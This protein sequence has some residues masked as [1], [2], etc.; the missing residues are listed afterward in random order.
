MLERLILEN[1]VPLLSSNITKVDLDLKHLITL[2]MARNG[3]GKSAI[4]RELNPLPPENGNY[5]AGGRKYVEWRVG[6]RLYKMDSNTG[7]GN[8]HSFRIDDGPELNTG[9]TF[10]AQKE[11]VYNHFNKMDG[12]LVKVL[13]GIKILDRL[14]AMSPGR[15]KDIILQVYPNDTEYALG[16]YFKL[17]QERNDLKAAIKNQVARYTEENNKLARINQLGIAEL[18]NR[19]KQIDTDLKNSLLLRGQLE[20]A[21]LDPDLQA[22]F[23]L[24]NKLVDKLLTNKLSGVMHSYEELQHAHEFAELLVNKYQ[25]QISVLKGVI[26]ES[27]S[28]LDGMEDLLKDPQ[29]FH[30]QAQHLAEDFKRTDES[31]KKFDTLLNSYPVFEEGGSVFGGIEYVAESFKSYLNRVAVAST[32]ELT[33]GTYKQWLLEQEQLA[34]KQRG[35]ASQLEQLRHKLKHYENADTINCP[36]CSHEFKVGIT[37]QD[38][39]AVRDQISAFERQTDEIKHRVTTLDNLIE[40]DAEWY[41]TMNQLFVFVRENSNVKVLP[42][43]IKHFDIGKV[44][45]SRL[46]NALDLFMERSKLLAY[47]QTLEDEK[48]V[49]DGRLELYARE[50][51]LDMATHVQQ[52][53]ADLSKATNKAKFYQ[54]RAMVLKEQLDAIQSYGNDMQ[55][56]RQ[57]QYELY[58]GMSNRADVQLRSYVDQNISTL[59][60]SKDEHLASIIQNK[61]LN[62]VVESISTDIENLKRR[63]NSVSVLMDS[64]CP[65]KGLIGKLMSDFINSLCGNINAVIKK[66]WN[67]PLYIKPCAKENGDLTY[68]FPVVTGDKAPTP[69]LSDCSGGETDV[70]DWAFRFVLLDYVGFPFPLIMDEIGVSFDEIKRGRFFNFIQEYT[71]GKNARQ[72]FMVSHYFSQYGI[73]K[74]P[75]VIGL[76]YEGLTMPGEPNKHSLIV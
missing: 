23:A 10:S 28:N 30:S 7:V 20:S 9:G 70:L 69:D 51:L 37:K 19:I 16:V 62:A 68:K 17:K 34:N 42:E 57:L 67:T 76:H 64:L 56:L 53:E 35:I 14:S 26:G 31:I 2:I 63:L 55:K 66:I 49:V 4:M 6:K 48:K 41:L 13:H 29:A 25:E 43:L 21:K 1:Y 65:N 71:Q 22:K 75:N 58:S 54:R 27:A 40:N 12:G 44:P 60:K 36:D 46:C 45:S 32:P 33:S 38:V 61:S 8:G 74:D 39:Q 5:T 24:F 59:T 73:F 47:R 50:N 72:L 18:E 15:R 11:L 3:T 52:L